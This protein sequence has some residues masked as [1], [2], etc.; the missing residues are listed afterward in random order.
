MGRLHVLLSLLA[1]KA[2]GCTSQ[3]HTATCIYMYHKSYNNKAFQSITCIRTKYAIAHLLMW[4]PPFLNIH[5]YTMQMSEHI[6][7]QCTLLTII[8]DYV[9][10]INFHSVS[11]YQSMCIS[12]QC[13]YYPLTL[14][15]TTHTC[16]QCQCVYQHVLLL[17]LSPLLLDSY[18]HTEIHRIIQTHIYTHTHPTLYNCIC[19]LTS[20]RCAV[21]MC[22][23]LSSYPNYEMQFKHMYTHVHVHTMLKAM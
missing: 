14:Y 4:A 23:L 12:L 13:R 2:S 7:L 6:F 9:Q 17:L 5:T 3:T 10:L 1:D 22:A 18:P 19:I 20:I 11:N 21:W 16:I 8:C 15:S